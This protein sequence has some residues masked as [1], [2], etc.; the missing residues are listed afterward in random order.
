M[1]EVLPPSYEQSPQSPLE[2]VL[3]VVPDED[4]TPDKVRDYLVQL[5]VAKRSLATDHAQCIADRW[6]I[7]T[8]KE[9]RS[10]TPDMYFEVFGRED[11]WH[12]YKEV[13]LH[14]YQEE[15]ETS[16]ASL[17]TCDLSLPLHCSDHKF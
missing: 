17:D 6:T 9:L 4:A 11:G 3:Q 8:G 1:Q 5:L 7:G 14:I 16:K 12:E 15:S 2:N 10:Y 13:K